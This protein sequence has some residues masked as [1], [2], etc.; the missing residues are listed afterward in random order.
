MGSIRGSTAGGPPNVSLATGTL[1]VA[2]GGTNSTTALSN[3]FFMSSQSGAIKEQPGIYIV[4]PGEGAA[5]IQS[6]IT[7]ASTAGGG[8]VQLVAGTYTCPTA[9]VWPSTANN[10]VLRGVGEATILSITIPLTTPR[11]NPWAFDMQAQQSAY[12]F[13]NTTAGNT[14][15]TASTH[16]DAANFVTD[17]LVSLR[18][19]DSDGCLRIEMNRVVSSNGTSG[20]VTLV[21]KIKTTLTSASLTRHVYGFGNGI[22]DLSIAHPSGASHSIAIR[23]GCV[24]CFVKNVTAN[25]A[26]GA[27]SV[28]LSLNNSIECEISSCRIRN[29]NTAEEY[30]N[31]GDYVGMAFQCQD[32]YGCIVKDTTWYNCGTTTNANL[33]AWVLGLAIEKC[34]FLNNYIQSSRY[35]AIQIGTTSSLVDTEFSNNV[36]LNSTNEAIYASNAAHFRNTTFRNNTIKHGLV[37]GLWL[38]T[39][40]YASDMKI[41]DN[42]CSDNAGGEGLSLQGLTNSVIS[43]NIVE[44]LTGGSGILT[45]LCTDCTITGNVSN[46]NSVAGIYLLDS[47]RLSISSN[48][49]KSN[50]NIG[51]RSDG[52]CANVSVQGGISISNTG[53]ALK[54][55]NGDSHWMVQGLVMTGGTKTLG[56]G[57]DINFFNNIE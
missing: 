17:D 27:V 26:T 24:R 33:P 53:D 39:T 23:S 1:P 16:S 11:T 21:S 6:A 37:G 45:Y 31:P 32:N 54:I 49:T 51:I 30:P 50:S 14:T 15:I 7:A 20:V 36:I 46:N 4:Q 34:K 41:I 42:D 38:V 2:N 55:A 18:G 40:A 19:T 48:V 43:G 29:Y 35:R 28:F 56:S 12:T 3:G 52:T 9:V 5:G 44:R 22:Q 47:S 57:T 8:I 10:V 25:G 13:D